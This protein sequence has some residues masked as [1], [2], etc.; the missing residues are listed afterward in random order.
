MVVVACVLDD[1]SALEMLQEELEGR[2]GRSGLS[3][4]E[5]MLYLPAELTSCI[6]HNRYRETPF[7][8]YEPDD[9]LLDTWPFLL[10]IRTDR[11]VTAHV[12]TIYQMG[13]T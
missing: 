7:T 10:I 9:P 4:G 3:Y 2:S 11:I 1:L 6:L 8:V 5:L 12:S 13:V